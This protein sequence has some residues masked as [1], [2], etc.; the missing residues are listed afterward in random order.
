MNDQA[1]MPLVSEDWTRGLAVVA[2]PDD[3]EY[4]MASAVARW[5]KQ[6]KEI[7]YLLATSGEAGIDSVPPDRA[8]ALRQVEQR[9]SA[10]LVGVKT[11][12]FL[13]HPDGTVV[14]SIELRRDLATAI[15]RHRPEVV[16]G[17]NYHDTFPG[18]FLNHADH[19]AVGR[20]VLDAI[21][22]AANRW[23]FPGAGGEPWGGVKFAIFGGS[24]VATN[25]I[26]VAD[27]ISDGVASLQ[28]HSAY[29]A[30][31]AAG[32]FGKDPEPFLL[33]MAQ[34]SGEAAGIDLAVL[35]ELIPF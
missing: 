30:A 28:A 12:E 19:K 25:A 2:H 35:V 14:E 29:L 17:M 18:G 5:T 21:R 23:V 16:V 15:R 24:P 32:T 20:A 33:G 13:A 22:D 26:D 6:G 8:A 9:T 3:L 34:L 1:K 10:A 4:G 11:V 31:L 7:S 27:T